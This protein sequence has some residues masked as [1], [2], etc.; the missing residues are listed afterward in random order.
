MMLSFI[1]SI[2]PR[3]YLM[4]TSLIA[5]GLFSATTAGAQSTSTAPSGTYACLINVNFSGYTAKATNNKKEAQ[6]VNAILIFTFDPSTPKVATLN[7]LVT[8]EVSNFENATTASISTAISTPAPVEFTV[9]P[10]ASS[11]YIY[12]LVSN[13]PGDV[14]YYIA[15]ANGGNTYFLQSGVGRGTGVCQSV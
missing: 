1:N 15:V 9:K 2:R 13:T 8:N 11:K 10:N 12:K 4:I 14:P 5:L 7:G 3:V 6:S